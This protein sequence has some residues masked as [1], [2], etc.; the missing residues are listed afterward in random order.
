MAKTK[1][2]AA[3]GLTDDK[4]GKRYKPGATVKDGD[5]PKYIIEDWLKRGRLVEEDTADGS[6][7][8][9]GKD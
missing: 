7:S 5:F 4:T 3:V 8:H 6:D 1:Y 2:I 9:D